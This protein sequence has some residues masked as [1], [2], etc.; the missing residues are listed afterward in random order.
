MYILCLKKNIFLYLFLE[1]LCINFLGILCIGDVFGY[2]ENNFFFF[3]Y[4]C[5]Y[6]GM[7]LK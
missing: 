7:K 4:C 5:L 1:Y 3:F 6:E 2:G